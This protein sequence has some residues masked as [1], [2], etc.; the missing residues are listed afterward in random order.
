MARATVA[1]LACALLGGAGA[2]ELTKENWETASAGKTVF[3]K[4]QAPW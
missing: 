3:V 2:M 1:V 4:F